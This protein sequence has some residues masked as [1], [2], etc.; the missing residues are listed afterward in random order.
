[1]FHSEAPG[2]AQIPQKE[3]YLGM[4][5]NQ[6][7]RNLEKKTAVFTAISMKSCWKKINNEG[8][9]FTWKPCLV[10]C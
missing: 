8:I 1:M 2:A 3:I 4:C 5:F 9:F 10:K 7:H 6:K